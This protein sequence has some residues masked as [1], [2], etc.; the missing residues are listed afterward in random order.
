MSIQRKLFLLIL[1]GCGL[2]LLFLVGPL[3]YGMTGLYE[4]I[5]TKGNNLAQ[6]VSAYTTDFAKEQTKDQLDNEVKIRNNNSDRIKFLERL[7]IESK[8]NKKDSSLSSKMDF[9]GI[10]IS[11][12]PK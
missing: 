6:L 3:L 9:S 8:R 5:D 11:K 12:L 10:D 7:R 1:A 2:S 4:A